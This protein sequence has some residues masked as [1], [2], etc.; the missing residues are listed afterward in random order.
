MKPY[1]QFRNDTSGNVA[2][3]FAI[4]LIPV[5]AFVGASIDFSRQLSAEN[6]LQYAVDSAV[7]NA[8]NLLQDVDPNTV[9]PEIVE[10]NL[11][12]AH[13]NSTAISYEIDVTDAPFSRTVS[14][15]A[16]AMLDTTLL[17]I[18]GLSELEVVASS[19]AS[20]S[21]KFTEVSLVLDISSYMEGIQFTNMQAAASDFVDTLFDA[22]A[23]GRTSFNLIPFGGNVNIG[24][25][26]DNYATPM[27]NAIVDPAEAD[28]DL[29]NVATAGYRFSDGEECIEYVIGDYDLGDISGQ[30]RSQVPHFWAFRNFHPWCPIDNNTALFN[31]SNRD[32]L[33]DAIN[34]FTL[35]DGTATDIGAMWG[36]KAL[37][38]QLKGRLG[39]DSSFRPRNFD[40]ER[41]T[42]VMVLM[43]D[44]GITDQRRPTDPDISS[45]HTNAAADNDPLQ[46]QTSGSPGNG[47]NR[48][49]II[50]EAEATGR[51]NTMCQLARDNDILVYTIAFQVTAQNDED[52]LRSCA[53]A[54]EFF[55]DVDNLDLESTFSSI[56]SS[57]GSL[58][59]SD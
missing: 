34:N 6:D 32:E 43:A 24:N 46:I 52:L 59:L 58:T 13:L 50:S 18:V 56:A 16:R 15:T 33:K 55:Y 20:Q 41:V 57:I 9:I 7:L 26:F 37:S 48:S 27:A 5:A 10:L 49:D 35:S 2:M 53:T 12:A 45:I 36:L 42:K 11:K 30:P 1:K 25:L 44:G 19:S 40:S 14:V 22:G 54:P 28:Y 29:N 3:I 21:F 4:C 39:G 38:P 23:Q 31:N 8:A 51:L 17:G 47:N